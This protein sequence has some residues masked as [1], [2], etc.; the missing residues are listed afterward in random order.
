MEGLAACA[1]ADDAVESGTGSS[2]SNQVEQVVVTARRREEALQEVPVAVSVISGDTLETADV[3]R[4]TDL[5]S[6][7][8]NL[9]INSGYR[10]G[11]LWISLRGIP[12]VQGG[13]PPV[14]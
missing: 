2:D 8:P 14:I 13:E 5:T 3:R 12:S 1:Y 6:M 4:V 9:S 11:S 10:Q 7:V